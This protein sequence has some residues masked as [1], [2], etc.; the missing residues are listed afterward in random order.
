MLLSF[1]I[2]EGNHMTKNEIRIANRLIKD[3]LARGYMISVHDG[4]E[5]ALKKS[6]NVFEVMNALASTDCD[7]VR[8]RDASGVY[9][10]TVALIWGNDVDLIS[11]WT[12]S[13]A[14]EALM[15]PVETFVNNTF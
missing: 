5:W 10:G 9:V 14:M 7:N 4:E 12:V 15:G 11:D 13:P 1:I 6:T 3:A 8:F 2:K